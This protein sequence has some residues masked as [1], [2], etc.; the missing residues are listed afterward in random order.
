M[1]I[2]E[3]ASCFLRCFSCCA[4]GFR[5]TSFDIFLATDEDIAFLTH[6]KTRTNGNS[7]LRVP[8]FCTLPYLDTMYDNQFTGHMTK[9]GSTEYVCNTCSPLVPTFDVWNAARTRRLYR[10]QPKVCC[11]GGC[12]IKCDHNRGIP[13]YI[14]NSSYPFDPALALDGTEANI[15]NLWG[16][17]GFAKQNYSLT[18]PKNADAEARATLIGATLLMEMLRFG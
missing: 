6:E 5:E 3:S 15:T 7:C 10:L 12:C 14:H 9:L 8:C 1:T 11:I 13:F 16:H 17:G 18:F 4:P 2:K